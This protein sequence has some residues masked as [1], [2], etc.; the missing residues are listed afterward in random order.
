MISWHALQSSD[1]FACDKKRQESRKPGEAMRSHAISAG[2]TLLLSVIAIS[3]SVLP[4]EV[5]DTRY[6]FRKRTMGG[7]APQLIGI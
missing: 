2:P 1:I 7:E 5:L 3:L 4:P 6:L